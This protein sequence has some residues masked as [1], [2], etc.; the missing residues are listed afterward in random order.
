MVNLKYVQ[1]TNTINL[2]EN[3]V[4]CYYKRIRKQNVQIKVTKTEFLWELCTKSTQNV[5]KKNITKYSFGKALNLPTTMCQVCTIN[6]TVWEFSD[7]G[8]KNVVIRNKRWI[9]QPQICP[10]YKCNKSVWEWNSKRRKNVFGKK[11][12]KFKLQKLMC[13]R[14]VY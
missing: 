9:W 8:T 11:I 12:Y 14:I 10:S 13:V 7:I 2:C 6:E 4:L 5:N 3:N 1:A